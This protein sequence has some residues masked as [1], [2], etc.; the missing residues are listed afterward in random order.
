VGPFKLVQGGEGAVG[1]L[2]VF[3]DDAEGR[4]SFW[5]FVSV[6]LRFPDALVGGGLP[7][8]A[9]AGIDHRL[10]RVEPASGQEQTIAHPRPLP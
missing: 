2:P 4:Q 5:G 10:W 9:A 7:Q 3:L 6:V 1:R 8:W